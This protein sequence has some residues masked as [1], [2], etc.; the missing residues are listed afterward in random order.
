MRRRAFLTALLLAPWVRAEERADALLVG[1]SLAF[2][3][4]PA[5]K[6]LAKARGVLLRV[7]ARG[8]TSTR[9]WLRKGWLV[10][11]LVRHRPKL[12]LVSLGTNCTRAER[13]VLGADIAKLLALV[14][15]STRVIWLFPPP[16]RFSHQY[17]RDALGQSEVEV[18][19]A[20]ELKLEK[21]RVHPT[22]T[23]NK[24]WAR[25][26]AEKLW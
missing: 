25:A 2:G 23:A 5:L 17:L 14:P 8:G 15:S 10:A 6:P 9:Q 16:M 1:D 4:G 24:K 19:E 20:G 3:L 13:K 26:L 7:N 12:L 18:I 22:T 11:T 21:D